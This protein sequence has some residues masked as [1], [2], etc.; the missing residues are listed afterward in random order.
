MLE[1][2]K[3]TREDSKSLSGRKMYGIFH[4]FIRIYKW[5][6][7]ND[8]CLKWLHSSIQQHKLHCEWI[9]MPI[10]GIRY[11]ALCCAV[12]LITLKHTFKY[13][14]RTFH[15]C[16]RFIVIVYKEYKANK[17]LLLMMKMMKKKKWNNG[18][19]NNETRS[20][21]W[22]RPQKWNG[23]NLIQLIHF[24]DTT[25][26]PNWK[27]NSCAFARI[28]LDNRNGVWSRNFANRTNLNSYIFH[29]KPFCIPN[30]RAKA[31]WFRLTA[32]AWLNRIITQLEISQEGN[33]N[34]SQPVCI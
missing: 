23:S 9:F 5:T 3:S 25:H 15:T 4:N 11:I 10:Y 19:N 17:L 6:F 32:V 33:R 27:G 34:Y 26:F 31:S 14:Q 21:R 1:T 22:R 18:N 12:Y 7:Q 20:R 30:D 28:L 13:S 24:H 16:L 2:I 8:G 29:W